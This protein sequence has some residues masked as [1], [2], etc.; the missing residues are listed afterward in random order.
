LFIAFSRL[1]SENA[2][3]KE[4][5][6]M[7][8]TI[9]AEDALSPEASNFDSN[10]RRQISPGASRIAMNTENNVTAVRG[11]GSVKHDNYGLTFAR[12]CLLD[13]LPGLAFGV[14]TLVYLLSFLSGLL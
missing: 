8:V 3:P 6:K 10:L 5:P 13:E 12:G 4:E 11:L 14:V 2:N 1:E 9:D 7:E